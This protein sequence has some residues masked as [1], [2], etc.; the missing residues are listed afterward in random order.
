MKQ[1]TRWQKAS[2]VLLAGLA[3]VALGHVISLEAHG[4]RLLIMQWLSTARNALSVPL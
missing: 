3:L 4:A 2:Q 1:V